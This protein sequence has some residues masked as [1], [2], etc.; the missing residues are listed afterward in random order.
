MVRS[1]FVEVKSRGL[2]HQH[3]LYVLSLS[4]GTGQDREGKRRDSV[5]EEI[6]R[7]AEH[8]REMNISVS[9][10][11]NQWRWPGGSYRHK[12]GALGGLLAHTYQHSHRHAHSH[13]S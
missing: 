2:H 13:L 7:L 1:N 9:G 8:F 4:H 3:L 11:I 6:G 12:C 5:G 10:S